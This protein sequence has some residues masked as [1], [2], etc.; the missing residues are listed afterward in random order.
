[1]EKETIEKIELEVRRVLGKE[2]KAHREHVEEQSQRI[3][4]EFKWILGIC[5]LILF[6]G[7]FFLFQKTYFDLEKII[8]SNAETVANEYL[9][10]TAGN[11]IMTQALQKFA[12]KW[13]ESET[14][15]KTIDEVV[16]P[17][18]RNLGKAA[19][20]E[21]SLSEIVEA[22]VDN[23]LD[24][25]EI[26]RKI[27]EKANNAV[28]TLTGKKLN[29][30]VELKLR[31]IKDAYSKAQLIP[32]GTIIAWYSSEDVP[33]GWAVCD[34]RQGTPD[35]RNRFLIGAENKSALGTRSG[36]ESHDHN[37]SVDTTSGSPLHTSHG[38]D[39]PNQEEFGS[40][41]HTHR[42][43]YRGQT[44]VANNVPPNVAVLFIMKL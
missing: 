22:K 42:V 11:N 25:E 28:A 15:A 43:A 6:G 36:S 24:A 2:V 34:G 44:K 35:L 16:E 14:F 40:V 30:T 37:F 32:R 5:G 8:K 17:R 26:K 31:E 23:L 12:D 18:V 20:D 39:K 3:F 33:F 10:S 38:P 21:F 9:S 29:Q 7:F 13:T 1:M 4:R 41:I 27:V 19:V